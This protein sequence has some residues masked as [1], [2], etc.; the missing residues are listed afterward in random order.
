MQEPNTESIRAGRIFAERSDASLK[1][2]REGGS[3]DSSTAYGRCAGPMGMVFA[4]KPTFRACPRL[5][6]RANVPGAHHTLHDGMSSYWHWG[7]RSL[8]SMKQTPKQ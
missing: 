7:I 3:T 4:M 8:C 5:A 6:S 2:A 1:S